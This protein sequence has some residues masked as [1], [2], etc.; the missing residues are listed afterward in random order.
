MARVTVAAKDL[1]RFF[2]ILG[3][4]VGKVVDGDDTFACVYLRTGTAVAGDDVS[5]SQVLTGVTTDGV[6]IGRMHVSCNGSLDDPVLLPSAVLNWIRPALQEVIRGDKNSLVSL[7]VHRDTLEAKLIVESD[8]SLLHQFNLQP[9][10]SYPID[11]CDRSLAGLTASD[12]VTDSD[13]RPLD[14]GKLSVFLGPHLGV[15]VT[16]AKKLHADV[17]LH[18][19]K[20]PASA[21]LVSIG[22]WRGVLPGTRYS[23]DIDVDSPEEQPAL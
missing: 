21:H 16:L 14:S 9:V 12:Q 3:A 6:L 18:R 10:G 13:H 15:L 23:A 7:Q 22:A 17:Y 5:A 1:Q 20:H 4:T 8:T 11:L 19:V 2:E